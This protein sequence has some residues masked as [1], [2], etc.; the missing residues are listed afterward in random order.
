[1]ETPMDENRLHEIIANNLIHL[2]NKEQNHSPSMR[3]LST[4]LGSSDGYIQKIVGKKAFPSFEK[5][6]AISNHYEIEPWSLLY[7]ADNNSDLQ[8]III[9]LSTCPNEMLP[10][11]KAY[12]EYLKNNQS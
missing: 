6:L 12:I 4:C 2:M 3:Y 9:E 1:M 7:D 10:V 5:L 8:D 11:I